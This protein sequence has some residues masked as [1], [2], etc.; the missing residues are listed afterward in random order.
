ML[1]TRFQ[2]GRTVQIVYMDRNGTLTQ[3]LVRVIRI[4]KDGILG[5]CQ[6]RKALRLFMT[7]RILAAFPAN[8][9]VG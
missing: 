4:E 1:S 2:A 6:T 9:H 8:Q 3:R 5:W 7:E